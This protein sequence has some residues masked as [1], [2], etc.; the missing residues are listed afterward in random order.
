MW[1]IIGIV[2]LAFFVLL[3]LGMCRAAGNYDRE[4][5]EAFERDMAAQKNTIE[6]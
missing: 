5:E 4:V 1:W 2:V 6:T 3:A